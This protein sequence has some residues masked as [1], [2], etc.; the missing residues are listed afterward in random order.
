MVLGF[1]TQIRPISMNIFHVKNVGAVFYLRRRKCEE[2][3]IGLG[4]GGYISRLQ[5]LRACLFCATI[6]ITHTV[7]DLGILQVYLSMILNILD[8]SSDLSLC[9]IFIQL[10]SFLDAVC[11]FLTVVVIFISV[12]DVVDVLDVGEVGGGDGWLVIHVYV[13]IGGGGL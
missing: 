5:F 12:V 9:L 13:V 6:S 1:L 8:F 3:W 2:V 4:D 7:I 10:C 11:H